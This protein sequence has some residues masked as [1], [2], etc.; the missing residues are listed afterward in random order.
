MHRL[1]SYW[2]KVIFSAQSQHLWVISPCMWTCIRASF[3][4]LQRAKAIFTS[5]LSTEERYF[6]GLATLK[7]TLTKMIKSNTLTVNP[8]D[9]LTWY[10]HSSMKVKAT[11]KAMW[12]RHSTSHNTWLYLMMLYNCPISASHFLAF[13][14]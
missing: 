4:V 8:S 12:S 7:C 1:L 2:I 6:V 14:T 13:Y 9:C 3:Y 5:Y 10:T 11:L